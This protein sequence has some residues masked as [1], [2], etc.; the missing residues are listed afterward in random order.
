MLRGV[1][2][3]GSP[4]LSLRLARVALGQRVEEWR[5]HSLEIGA[6][7]TPPGFVQL[8]Q[9]EE[10]WGTCSPLPTPTGTRREWPLVLLFVGI[11]CPRPFSVNPGTSEAGFVSHPIVQVGLCFCISRPLR[12]S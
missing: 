3:L 4:S 9:N 12:A 8:V 10:A 5:R 7:P 2:P 11:F 1:I 6:L